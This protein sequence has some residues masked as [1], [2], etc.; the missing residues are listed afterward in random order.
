V[1]LDLLVA[2]SSTGATSRDIAT[3]ISPKGNKRAA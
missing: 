3:A 2:D 1:S